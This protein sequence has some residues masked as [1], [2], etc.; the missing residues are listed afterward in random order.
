MDEPMEN[1]VK[2]HCCPGKAQENH[3][4]ITEEKN[5]SLYRVQQLFLNTTGLQIHICSAGFFFV[6]KGRE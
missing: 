6:F 2:K 3:A 5:T 4:E 1:P